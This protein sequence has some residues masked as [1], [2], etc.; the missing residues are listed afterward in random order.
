MLKVFIVYWIIGFI[1]WVLIVY[2]DTDTKW[3][4]DEPFAGIVVVMIMSFVI[5]IAFVYI[6]LKTFISSLKKNEL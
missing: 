4:K 2:K 5:P 6:F 1:M 3:I